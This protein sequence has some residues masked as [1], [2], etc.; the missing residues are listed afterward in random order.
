M[1]TIT[2]AITCITIC[3]CSNYVSFVQATHLYKYLKRIDR[4]HWLSQDAF[5]RSGTVPNTKPVRCLSSENLFIGQDYSAALGIWF[6]LA[7]KQNKL[8]GPWWD[9]IWWWNKIKSET[10]YQGGHNHFC[11]KEYV[12][13]DP[14]LDKSSKFF[15]PQENI[16]IS[17]HALA[18]QK[19]PH[20]FHR[21]NAQM[22]VTFWDAMYSRTCSCTAK[23]TNTKS[24]GKTSHWGPPITLPR[25]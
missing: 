15:L 11:R 22:R 4:A 23:M 16:Y 21:H 10:N 3:S 5:W 1:R 9:M 14:F 20:G 18:S 6:V 2:I 25:W 7:G 8:R 12:H 17:K 19:V 24:L 13:V